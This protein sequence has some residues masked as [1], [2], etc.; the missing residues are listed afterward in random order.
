LALGFSDGIL[1]A[2][3][4]SSATLLKHARGL[5][6]ELA[7][8]VGCVAFVTAIITMFIA[9]YAQTR[10]NLSRA[11]RQLNLSASGHLAATR[12]GRRAII[13]AAQAA[14]IAS[15]ASFAG[16][17]IPLAAAGSVP[18]VAWIGLVIAIALLGLF[19]VA[20]A[21]SLDGRWPRWVIGMILVGAVVTAI[22]SQL[23][24]T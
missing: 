2:L 13:E 10:S 16:A 22:G 3:I 20:L 23:E 21:E 15:A 24:I 12:L 19:G 18:G 7:L 9:E 11:T 5:T 8:K 6:V 17:T 4:L 14:L 1:N